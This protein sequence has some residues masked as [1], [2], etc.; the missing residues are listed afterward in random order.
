MSIVFIILT[1]HHHHHRQK[2][3]V[4]RRFLL[5]PHHHQIAKWKCK[6]KLTVSN[7]SK[8]S[9]NSASFNWLMSEESPI[10]C[11]CRKTRLSFQSP[12]FT[13]FVLIYC[14]S[15]S[16]VQGYVLRVLLQL[17]LQLIYIGYSYMLKSIK[18]AIRFFKRYYVCL[19][20]KPFVSCFLYLLPV[21][22]REVVFRNNLGS[23]FT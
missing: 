10:A 18:I 12:P 9:L 22:E 4:N 17:I 11:T 20:C 1:I 13:P 16:S 15:A 6:S 8:A 21:S 3:S 2:E 14:F 23:N 5:F 19:I 7:S